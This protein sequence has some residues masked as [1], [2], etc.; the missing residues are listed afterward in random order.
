[1]KPMIRA[2]VAAGAA[3]CCAS[4]MAQVVTYGILDSG[5]EYVSNTNAA[6]DSVWKI[7][8]ATS[9][10]P[11]RLGFKGSED[12][13]NGLQ[14][15]F[16]LESGLVPDT[17]AMGQ[18]GRLFGRQSYVGLK[19]AWGAL[20]LGRQVNMTFIAGLKADIM[21]PNVFGNGSIDA[22]LPNARSDNAIG[23]LG[24]FR[25]VTVGATYS[26][27]RDSSN[28]GGPAATGCAG[29][30][31]ASRKACRQATALLAYDS[32][33]FGAA[34]AYDTMNGGAGAAAPLNNPGY[35]DVR[36]NVNGYAM[37]GKAKLGMGLQHRRT[38]AM[39][40]QSSDLYFVGASLPVAEL[41]TADAQ[42]SRYILRDSGKAA[43]LSVARLTY[44]LSKRTALHA[45]YGYM[46][47]SALAAVSLDPGGS[48]GTGMNQTGLM[49][50]IRHAF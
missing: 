11:S 9:S 22:Y 47:N 44:F 8:S 29:E 24:S 41:W 42:L 45:S 4:G 30:S 34:L 21:G 3:L 6:G 13:G 48:V 16:V 39:T 7:P 32:A 2:A 18:G 35:Q 50:G 27:G 1:M 43:T 23:Y 25:G 26:L 5:L 36:T 17:G 14:A 46:H 38:S 12:L 28:A 10:V 20:T 19:G 40:K 15:V 31:A 49:A 33:Q 37:L